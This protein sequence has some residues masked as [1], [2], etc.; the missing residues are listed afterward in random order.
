MHRVLQAECPDCHAMLAEHERRCDYCGST[1]I[2]D[3][4]W[5]DQLTRER[6]SWLLV[7]ILAAA[8]VITLV[9]DNLCGTHFAGDAWQWLTTER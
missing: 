4:P 2:V 9:V 5:Y 7:G 1:A 8:A 6:G 3:V